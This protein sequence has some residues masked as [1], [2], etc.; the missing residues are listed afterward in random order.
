MCPSIVWVWPLSGVISDQ[1]RLVELEA[2]R[3]ERDGLKFRD[4]LHGG[5]WNYL[6]GAII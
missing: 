4:I 6:N 2:L 1:M 5:S 3:A